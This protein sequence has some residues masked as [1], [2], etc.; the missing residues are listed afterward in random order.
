[1][2]K[3]QWTNNQQPTTDNR[4]LAADFA[5]GV[6]PDRLNGVAAAATVP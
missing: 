4:H 3:H 1:M 6:L 5:R 2:T